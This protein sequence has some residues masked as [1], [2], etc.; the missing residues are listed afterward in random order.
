MIRKN[1]LL[2]KYSNYSIGGPASFFLDVSNKNDLIDGLKNWDKKNPIFILGKGTNVLIDEKGFNGLII[3][4]NILGIEL[5]GDKLKVGAGVLFSDLLK[6]CIDNS[7]S[8]LEWAGG[9]P[10]SVGGAVRGNA[11]AFKSEIKDNVINVVSINLDTLEEVSRNNSDCEFNYRT[12]IFKTLKTNEII[13]SV[14]F[15]M[16][17][18]D[19]NMINSLIQEKIEYR[20]QKHPMDVPSLGSTFKNIPVFSLNETQKKYLMQYVKNDPFPVIPV[21]KLLLLCDLKGKR[22]GNAQI[23]DKHPNFIVNL[24]GAKASDVEKLIEHAKSSVKKKFGISIE[25]EIMYLKSSQSRR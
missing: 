22:E 16:Q 5:E 11:G 18:G 14:N 9:L 21:A 1:I 8:G 25:E 23:S 7:L 15:S 6:F 4:N 10:G 19:S 20:N 2:S 17:K 12:S 24:G 3:H 13:M